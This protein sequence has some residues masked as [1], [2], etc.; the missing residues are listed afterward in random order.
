MPILKRRNGHYQA[1]LVGRDGKII[2]KTFPN[3]RDA[4]VQLLEWRQE[5]HEG[6]LGTQALMQITVEDFFHEWFRDVNAEVHETQATG[7]R[8]LQKQFYR[9]YIGPVLG[10]CQLRA[11]TPQLAK[12]V[13]N[14]MAKVGRAPQTQRLVYATMRKMFGDAVENYQYLTFNPIIR[15]IKPT[16]PIKEAKHLN[17]G[18]LTRLLEFS[19][20][21]KYGLAIWIQLYLGLR[22]GELMALRWEDVDLEVGRIHIRR[23]YVKKTGFFREYPK[24]GK[25]HSHTIPIEL[26]E[27]LVA[28]KRESHSEL[29][30]SSPHEKGTILPYRWYLVALKKYCNE[31]GITVIS[32]HGLRHSTSELYIH[33]GA[34]RDDLRRL[35]AHS[36]PAITDR[37]VHDRGTNLE[38]VANVIRLFPTGGTPKG[39]PREIS[40]NR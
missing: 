37:Y 11:V 1:R 9:D 16:V 40:S 17:L 20:D 29:V 34:T 24:G 4:E 3:R 23:T 35:F 18:Q 13:L 25:Q 31:L 14:E 22:A 5:K 2:C 10:K 30:L 38:K 21:K 33:H 39:T 7:W 26:Q 28:A 27:K 8:A 15:K 32:S 19:A 12:R 6:T 36:T